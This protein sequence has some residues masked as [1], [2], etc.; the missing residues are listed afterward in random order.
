[1]EVVSYRLRVRVT[2]PKYAINEEALP[3]EP[4]L[5]AAARK[6]SRFAYFDG[7]TATEAELYE[8]DRLSVGAT[9]PGPAIIEQFDATTV[10]PP[11]WQAHV[12]GARNLILEPRT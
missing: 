11:E 7:A 9:I 6:G 4:L 1:V 2:V 5:L 10:I 12:D 8:R 3:R